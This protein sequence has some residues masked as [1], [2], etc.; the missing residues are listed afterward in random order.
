MAINCVI[1]LELGDRGY[2]SSSSAPVTF[3]TSQ[4]YLNPADYDGATYYFEIVG[5]NHHAT[6][7]YTVDLMEGANVMASLILAA[8]TPTG[9]SD[10]IRMRSTSFVPSSGNHV[11]QLRLPQTAAGN[12]VIVHAVRI[13]VA[14]LGATITRLQFPLASTSVA[15]GLDSSG[16]PFHNSTS[17]SYGQSDPVRCALLLLEKTLM[18]TI[19]AGTPWSWETVGFQGLAATA[20]IGLF[21]A[22]ANAQVG[23]IE[24]GHTTTTAGILTQDFADNLLTDGNE[25]E[26]RVKSSSGAIGANACAARLYVRLTSASKAAI[27][28]RVSTAHASLGSSLELD[29]ARQLIDLTLF[30]GPL[31]YYEGTGWESAAGTVTQ[32]LL[33]DGTADQSGGGSALSGSPL[34]FNGSTRIR[35]RSAALTLVS[36]HRLV[37]KLT[38]SSGTLQS[39]PSFLIVTVGPLLA[40]TYGGSVALISGA[41][42]A[43]AFGTIPTAVTALIAG[44]LGGLTLSGSTVGAILGPVVLVSV[45]LDTGTEYN[46]A[47]YVRHPSRLYEGRV[48]AFGTVERSIPIPVGPPSIGN[49]TIT[50]ADGDHRWRKLLA[51]RTPFRR[52]LEVKI[53]QENMSE[54]LFQTAYKGEIRAVHFDQESVSVE[55]ADVSARWFDNPIPPLINKTNFPDAAV[56]DEFFPLVFGQ[57]FDDRDQPSGAIRCHLIDR[58]LN[59]YAV[60]RTPCEDVPAVYK[61][62]RA[63][64]FSPPQTS[65]AFV[66]VDPADYTVEEILQSIEGIDYT[67]TVLTFHAPL[68]DG[69]PIA[70][71]STEVRCDV[72]GTNYRG[73]FGT[74]APVTGTLQ[75]PIDTLINMLYYV[76]SLTEP[77]IARYSVSSFSTIRDQFTALGWKCDGAIVSS[78]TVREFLGQWQTSFATDFYQNRQAELEVKLTEDADEDRPVFSDLTE[79][80]Q[81]S[82]QQDLPDPT[83][84]RII[85]KWKRLYADDV[86][87]ETSIYENTADQDE[88]TLP[89]HSPK[90]QPETVELNFIRDQATADAV[91]ASRASYEDLSSY[92]F[93]CDLS[94]PQVLDLLE[95]GTLVGIT[96]AGGIQDGGWVN[97][98]FKIY[99]ESLNLDDLKLTIGAIRRAVRDPAVII[100]TCPLPEGTEGVA[101]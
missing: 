52:L 40:A 89:F 69:S 91:I 37:P 47:S 56:D 63:E 11:Y 58:T 70:Y 96:H 45:Y 76:L 23:S 9:A 19:A 12:N 5:Y 75:N 16:A 67:L 48:T 13:V 97:E 49:L 93:Q 46:A 4:M 68:D 101:Y 41:V 82:V 14:Q 7:P 24:N 50:W 65:D 20:S 83:F 100:T 81:G 17:T 86:W 74:L 15:S 26:V 72:D 21:D 18:A 87:G 66:L 55:V 35:Q 88:L 27:Y 71:G 34:T 77:D 53:G 43:R 39:G 2:G 44:V 90:I 85:Y 31:A 79:I 59:R 98:E 3:L 64:D 60:S 29:E 1:T 80:L 36:G 99:R 22:T 42:A 10:F 30:S 8:N 95:L 84:N 6:L 57:V 28:R 38:R 78:M 33:D 62:V 32:D 73:A 61:K 94:A 92:R 25:L 54:V 51:L